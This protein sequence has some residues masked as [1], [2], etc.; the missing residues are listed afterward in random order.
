VSAARPQ[1]NGVVLAEA[2]E[3]VLPA[4]EL[5]RRA[6]QELLRQAA[7][8]AGLLAG[9]DPAP[10]QGAPSEAASEAIEALLAQTL[11][12]PEPDDATCRR[13]H[14]A[15]PARF[16]QGERVRV[17]HILFAVTDGV[18]IGRLRDRA[19]ACLVELRSRSRAEIEGTADTGDRF[20]EAAARLSNCP[21][22]GQGGA[23]G[24]LAAADC[25]PEFGRALFGQP[26]LGI[27][28]RLVHSR[29]GLHVVE[30]LERQPGVVP[31]FEAVKASVRA[32]LQRQAFATALRQRLQQLAG[33]A[34][35]AGVELDAADS[36]LLQ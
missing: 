14:A 4:D 2:A 5:R 18:D 29:F 24:W 30:V 10:V 11:A 12:V 28:P 23:L 16:A 1:V 31:S 9:D 19:E 22:G 32:A 17:R 21:S 33:H 15:N 8:A 25:A 13:W 36:P 20:A 34:Q 26:E 6:H 27:L 35:I 3:G 7:I